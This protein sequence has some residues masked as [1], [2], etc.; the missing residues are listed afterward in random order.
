MTAAK[1]LSAFENHDRDLLTRQREIESARKTARFLVESDLLVILR[2]RTGDP[3]WRVWT[4][5]NRPR[6]MHNNGRY[7]TFNGRYVV[8]HTHHGKTRYHSLEDAA[9]AIRGTP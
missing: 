7:I 2:D 5:G 6:F 1:L 3:E 9:D 8:L 4:G